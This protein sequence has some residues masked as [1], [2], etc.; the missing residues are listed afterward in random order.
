MV[1]FFILILYDNP[2]AKARIRENNEVSAFYASPTAGAK[3]PGYRMAET[4]C[5]APGQRCMLRA[6]RTQSGQTP[7]LRNAPPVG[8]ESVPTGCAWLLKRRRGFIQAHPP[9]IAGY[10]R[11]KQPPCITDFQI[12][13]AASSGLY[14]LGSPLYYRAVFH[15]SPATGARYRSSVLPRRSWCALP[16]MVMVRLKPYGCRFSIVSQRRLGRTALHFAPEAPG[17]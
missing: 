10:L 8:R 12:R 15:T 1:D 9:T 4:A 7:D 14:G 3:R 6:T 2:S 13:R 17:G 11:E 5:R 16:A